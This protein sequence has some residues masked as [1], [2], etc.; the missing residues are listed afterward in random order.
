VKARQ[1]GEPTDDAEAELAK[2]GAGARKKLR[3]T[4][5]RDQIADAPWLANG[6]DSIWNLAGKLTRVPSSIWKLT[7]PTDAAAST[8]VQAPGT[9]AK[10]FLI[11]EDSIQ[12][13]Q[14]IPGKRTNVDHIVTP[15]KPALKRAHER[16]AQ[17]ERTT[18]GPA[19]EKCARRRKSA[20]KSLRKSTRNSIIEPMMNESTE[21]SKERE[22]GNKSVIRTTLVNP[23]I[24]AIRESTPRKN[25]RRST[26]S[27]RSSIAPL[28]DSQEGTGDELGGFTT[29]QKSAETTEVAAALDASGVENNNH[30][31]NESDQAGAM[32]TTIPD[33]SSES[34]GANAQ[35]L[36]GSAEFADVKDE[37]SE[38][39]EGTTSE[40]DH[41]GQI[42]LEDEML[43]S[44]PGDITKG[45]LSPM[46]NERVAS[47]D[48]PSPTAHTD[49]E[50]ESAE[51]NEVL[52]DLTEVSIVQA[53]VPEQPSTAVKTAA[54]QD[55]EMEDFG[56]VIDGNEAMSPINDTNFDVAEASP[57]STE[58]SIEDADQSSKTVLGKSE[59]HEDATNN[60]AT[61]NYHNDD[62]DMLLNFLTRVKADK[63]AKAQ[64]S[65]PKPRRKRSLPHSPLR[66][67]LGDMDT[68]LSPSPKKPTDAPDFDAIILPESPS[69]SKRTK[70]SS[71]VK[72]LDED[73]LDL[74]K[75]IRRS[76]RTRLPVK[77]D[78]VVPGGPSFIPVR[79]LGQDVDTTVTLKRTADKELAALTRVNTRKNKGGAV[80]ALEVLA[81]KE[82]EKEDPVMR[83]KML[84]EAFDEKAEKA[85]RK[86]KKGRNVAWA[87]ELA[88]FQ[89]IEEKEPEK[90]LLEEK[91]KPVRV[92]VRSKIAL[93][94]AM[95]GTPA[96]KRRGRA[97]A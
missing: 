80:S 49:P 11:G 97:K 43:A 74:N 3:K 52:G 16:F 64:K 60:S 65:S 41:V 85:A 39:M 95:N 86:N 90:E 84:K 71:P 18:E 58:D 94:M 44:P 88:R 92:G 72:T 93:G 15:R 78:T 13:I 8:H 14:L 50:E 23:V 6:P 10:T 68:N 36:K 61:S 51:K 7:I 83:Q 55:T 31:T 91:K 38:Q 34:P 81:K 45:E 30:M 1:L 76:G 42:I 67:P 24:E 54:E 46:E 21:I 33:I 70:G 4:G 77:K 19:E 37:G 26:R 5:A 25:L 12:P 59:D 47:L 62:T 89:S 96:P 73:T 63:A 40:D 57:S 79:R 56:P 17:A 35:D 28:K 75:P 87:A 2:E 20:R 82:A 32:V 9:P 27:S 66:L 29:S 22:D 48:V 69:K 53:S